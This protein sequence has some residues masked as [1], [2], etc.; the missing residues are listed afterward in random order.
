ML[1]AKKALALARQYTDDS[2]EGAGALEGKPCQIQSITPI[3]GGNRVVFLWLDNSGTSHTDSMDVMDGTD[4]TNGTNGTDGVGIASIEKTGTSGLVDTYTI[5]LTDGNTET[6]T[7]TNGKDGT[8]GTNGTDGTDGTDGFSPIATVTKS[9]DVYTISIEDKNGTTTEQIDLGD[10]QDKTLATPLTIGGASQT[11][12]EGALG[13]LNTQENTLFNSVSNPNLLDNAWFTVNQRGESNY[14]NVGYC[15]DRWILG[16]GEIT[17]RASNAPYVV[18]KTAIQGNNAWLRQKTEYK[19]DTTKPITYSAIIESS[20]TS[21]YGFALKIS[22]MNDYEDSKMQWLETTANQKTLVKFTTTPFEQ[23]AFEVVNNTNLDATVKIYALKAE[24]GTISTLET[25]IEPNY[26]TEL[27][28]CQ[29]YFQRIGKKTNN[30]AGFIFGC[31]VAFTTS[32]IWMPFYLSVPMRIDPT[33]TLDGD[34][35]VSPSVSS[36]KVSDTENTLRINALNFNNENVN[37]INIALDDSSA[38]FAIGTWYKMQSYVE[39]KA[40]CIN[41]SAD[42]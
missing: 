34:F 30:N 37:M 10:K 2:L 23:S 1:D 17:A 6:F 5:T 36:A 15:L 14:S 41:L 20:V 33:L 22:N 25:D 29:R 32:A 16:K 12:V 3:T 7:V 13:A 40:G 42:L 11:T 4:G 27:A 8:N 24:M 38:P 19:L 39:T 26:A 9:G 31:G 28:K 35:L 18:L 21:Q